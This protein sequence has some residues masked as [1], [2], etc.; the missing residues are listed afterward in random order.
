[1]QDKHRQVITGWQ[2]FCLTL[3]GVVATGVFSLARDVAEVAGAGALVAIPLTGVVMLVKLVGIHLLAN[4]FPEQT[5]NEYSYQL[6][7]PVL[8][9]VYLLIYGLLSLAVAISIPRAHFPL[10]AAWALG[11]TPK[12]AFMAPLAI[13]CW[14]VV[15]RGVVVTARVVEMFN[16][17]GLA[18]MLLLMVPVIPVDLDFVRPVFEQGPASIMRGIVPALFAFS[19]FD[20]YLIVF[21]YVR[22]KRKFWIGAAA[23]G[24]A[25][26]FYTV[27]TFL[28][29]GN[30]GLEFTLLSTWPLQSYLNRFSLAVFERADVV[31]LIAWIFQ[32]INATI[33]VMF[34]AVSCLQG[35]FP[36]VRPS[37]I[38]YLLL[39][40]SLAGVAYPIYSVLEAQII[41]TYS[42]VAIAFLGGTPWLLWLL[43]L[44]R[45]KRGGESDAQKDAA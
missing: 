27:T 33:V 20:V 41:G 34:V 5:L 25:T 21:P 36:R 40:L 19:G 24:M 35:T 32:V 17:G 30:L 29:I 44:L 14:N 8:A 45:G 6:L 28:I 42:L 16:Y 1:M 12:I 15:K 2:L 38:H 43:A 10:V 22:S 39:A 4:R 23:V 26:L 11:L 13:V 18:L 3:N 37:F 9:K 31:F 7:G